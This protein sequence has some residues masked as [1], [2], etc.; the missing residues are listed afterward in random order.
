[1]CQASVCKHL[2]HSILL[3]RSRSSSPQ[4]NNHIFIHSCIHAF[5]Y[6]CIYNIY[7]YKKPKIYSFSPLIGLASVVES[8]NNYSYIHIFICSYSRANSH[9]LNIHT[10]YNHYIHIF[11][12][13]TFIHCISLQ[14]YI[15]T[16]IHL[17]I[18][19]CM[20][21]C[22]HTYTTFTSCQTIIATN[23]PAYK[24]AQFPQA[25]SLVCLDQ[26]CHHSNPFQVAASTNKQF[27]ITLYHL[28]CHYPCV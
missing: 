22:I 18:H 11:M 4:T 2:S 24:Y 28:K 20:H 3:V 12:H 7:T 27:T 5:M 8:A 10:S 23:K 9:Q 26:R 16:P 1:M 13:H 15:H 19:A 21:S 17:C 25:S 14:S 6:T